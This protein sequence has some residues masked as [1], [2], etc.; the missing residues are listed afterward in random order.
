MK[1]TTIYILTLA[2]ALA[3]CNSYL[4]V[5]PKGFSIPEAYKDYRLLINNDEL[6]RSTPAY[7]D[8]LADNV[9]PGDPIDAIPLAS[10]DSF[11]FQHLYRF[12]E[13]I[14][15]D[16]NYWDVAYKHIFTYNV[17]INNVLNSSGGSLKEKQGLWAEA[18]LGRAFIYF[19]LVNFFGRHI[20]EATSSSDL[21][22]PLLLTEDINYKYERVSV[23]R[24]YDVILQDL[25]E[26]EPFLDKVSPNRYVPRT[27][28]AHAFLSRVYL[29]QGKYKEAMTY[30][31]KV[32]EVENQLMNWDEYT[33]KPKTKVGRII[34]TSA[35]TETFPD[36]KKNIETVWGRTALS[37][38][39][40]YLNE[41]VYATDELVGL[42]RAHLSTGAVDKRFDLNF[43]T[44][45][46]DLNPAPIAIPGRSLWCP[47]I[48]HVNTGFSTAEMYL[49]AAECEAR[50]GSSEE[51]MKLVNKLRHSR[52]IGTQDVTGLSKEETLQFVLD[53]RRREFPVV[54]GM[55]LMDVKRLFVSGDLK[56]DVV[57][58]VGNQTW[59]ISPS[60]NR[61]ILP[62]PTK[63]LEFNKDMPL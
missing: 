7:P 33:I 5:K 24:I 29:F 57:H 58:Q 43:A 14:R 6:V 4:D 2:F 59:S 53:E 22:V 32:L 56:K 27:S 13:G 25:L 34:K 55:R 45:V 47:Y 60:D 1:K 9:R 48:F 3:G 44:D 26:A 35:P 21:G 20:N 61:M 63:I 8:L 10:F 16:D 40:G 46:S 49:I 52:I 15:Y 38:H 51:A 23:Q 30:A 28:S 18:K 41:Y 42:Y 31:K 19:N 50:I 54:A 62:I 39:Y 11:P 36:A 37:Q 17:I 12:D